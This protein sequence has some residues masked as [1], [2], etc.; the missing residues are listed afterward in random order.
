MP[1]RTEA[2]VR[3]RKVAV[4]TNPN[5]GKNTP[6]AG[7]GKVIA[8]ILTTPYWTYNT[9]TLGA[10]Q[11]AAQQIRHDRPD[12]LVI[13]GGDGTIHHTLTSV[14]KAHESAPGAPLPQ[15]L[16]IPIGTM[17]TVATSLGLTRHPAVRLA[18]LVATKIRENRPLDHV[19]LNPLKVNDEYGFLYGSGLVV[20]FLE[21]YYEDREQ[22]GPKRAVKV[23]LG[24]LGNE[25]VSAITFRKPTHGLM[26]PVHAK[27]ALPGGHEP[28]VAPLMTHTAILVG[29]VDQ[30]GMGCK[31][32]PDAR[33]H[34][35]KFMLRSTNLSFWGL[36]ANVGPLWA[37]FPLTSST[38]DATTDRLTIEYEEPTV[39][40]LDGD[41]KPA[42]AVDVIESGPTVPFVTG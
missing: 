31:G 6:R 5:A 12:I 2:Y 36:M 19:H 23:I 22:R 30:I 25:I 11:G 32:L 20:N 8:S 15:I 41:L 18:E 7:L 13:A 3:K 4:V 42:R 35:G 33:T 37:G 1:C 21:K 34:P 9:E 38:F 14:L 17:N 16:I 10:L 40:Q 39:V 26:K 27:I 29:A 28:P 24:A